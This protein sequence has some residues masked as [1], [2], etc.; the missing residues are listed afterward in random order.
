MCKYFTML[1]QIL[2]HTSATYTSTLKKGKVPPVVVCLGFRKTI[3]QVSV[4]TEVGLI[5]D[6]LAEIFLFQ[7][8]VHLQGQFTWAKLW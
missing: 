2:I 4:S 6:I 8:R 5:L 1:T 3:Q 7:Q